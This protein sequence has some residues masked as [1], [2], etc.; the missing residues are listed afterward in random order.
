MDFTITAVSP[1]DNEQDIKQLFVTHERPEFGPPRSSV[2]REPAGLPREQ[3]AGRDQTMG[4]RVGEHVLDL[5]RAERLVHHDGDRARGE[6]TEERR[7]RALRHNLSAAFSGETHLPGAPEPSNDNEAL[8]VNQSRC[9]WTANG[10][11]AR[12]ARARQE[13]TGNGAAPRKPLPRRPIGGVASTGVGRSA[14]VHSEGSNF[15]TGGA[16]R[17]RRAFP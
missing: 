5:A 16:A 12:V 7:G 10:G 8:R 17:Q 2:G 11:M 14:D 6:R 15:A 13:S 1:L 4:P 3:V 9:A